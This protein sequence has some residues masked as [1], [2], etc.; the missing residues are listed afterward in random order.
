MLISILEDILT[1]NF[2]KKKHDFVHSGCSQASYFLDFVFFWPNVFTKIKKRIRLFLFEKKPIFLQVIENTAH[3]QEKKHYAH[4]LKSVSW[5]MQWFLTLCEVLL[6][7]GAVLLIL[8]RQRTTKW[9]KLQYEFAQQKT[10]IFVFFKNNKTRYVF[11][12]FS[13]VK[14]SLSW[15]S[16]FAS[17]VIM[18]SLP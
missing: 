18:S 6:F 13:I 9:K 14:V 16:H 1:C 5:F 10:K 7:C 3:T 15:P 2:S 11:T 4:R 8:Y 12:H 17:S